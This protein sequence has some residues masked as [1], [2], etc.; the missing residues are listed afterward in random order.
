MGNKRS[1]EITPTLPCDFYAQPLTHTWK[2]M[3][4]A[5]LHVHSIGFYSRSFKLIYKTESVS[6]SFLRAFTI[7]LHRH[8]SRIESC[9]CPGPECP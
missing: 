4:C 6:F 9:G 7:V 1:G 3:L 2:S 5:D 8:I